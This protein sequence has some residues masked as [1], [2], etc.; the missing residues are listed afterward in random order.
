RRRMLRLHKP[1]AWLAPHALRR[2]VRH[3]ELS[4]LRLQPFQLVHERVKLRVGNFGGVQHVV[5]ILVVP[6]F[7]AKGFDLL[8]DD[9]TRH[10]WEIIVR[11]ELRTVYCLF[12]FRIRTLTA[13]ARPALDG[14]FRP[15]SSNSL[16]T[17]ALL[18]S[19][20]RDA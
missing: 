9:G 13:A 17:V 20:F 2:R 1:F 14:G 4:M 6:D 19:S 12:A 16:S 15:P 7:F 5:A 8:L 10:D 11:L 3:D 18:R